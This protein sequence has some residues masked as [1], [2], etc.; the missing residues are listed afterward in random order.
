MISYDKIWF[1]K[2][3]NKSTKY[4]KKTFMSSTTVLKKVIILSIQQKVNENEN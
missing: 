4:I 2:I 3:D 1:L